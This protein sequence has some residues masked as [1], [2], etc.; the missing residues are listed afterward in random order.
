MYS[1]RTLLLVCKR[2]HIFTI[3]RLFFF[4]GMVT[5][6]YK[7]TRVDQLLFLYQY[8]LLVAGLF[9]WRAWSRHWWAK[10]RVLASSSEGNK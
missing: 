1:L 6:F 9:C 5:S 2:V 4:S 8:V 3:M 7:L 10:S